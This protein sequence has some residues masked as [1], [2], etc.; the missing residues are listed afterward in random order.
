MMMKPAASITTRLSVLKKY[1]RPIVF[2]VVLLGLLLIAMTTSAY[3]GGQH[4]LGIVTAID[5][6]HIEVKTAKGKTVS[7]KLTKQVRFN[8]KGNPKSTAPPVVG[9][10]V[11]IEAEK[12]NKKLTAIVVHYSAVKNAPVITQ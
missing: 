4:V 8:N 12:E 5:E 6:K 2:R 9:D 10:R 11:I 1:D 7:V 3:G